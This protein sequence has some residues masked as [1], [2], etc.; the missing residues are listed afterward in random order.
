MVSYERIGWVNGTGSPLNASNLNKIDDGILELVKAVNENT[1]NITKNT[2]AIEA[3]DD[4]ADELQVS[5]NNVT[6]TVNTVKDTQAAHDTRI[7]TNTTNI[8][9]LTNAVGDSTKGLVKE[10]NDLKSNSATKTDITN[11]NT[12]LT[13]LSNTVTTLSGKVNTNE[14]DIS[15]IE[16]DVSNL[17]IRIS[18]AET[19]IDALK[20]NGGGSGGGSGAD[21]SQITNKP[22]T[23][24]PSKHVNSDPDKIGAATSTAYG[25]VKLDSGDMDTVTATTG[26]AAGRGHTHSNLA[27]KNPA[28]AD[29]D[30]LLSAEDKEKLDGIAAG[31]N[32]YVLPNIV[33]ESKVEST[34]TTVAFSIGD[35]KFSQ[36]VAVDGGSLSVGSAEKLTTARTIE[37]TGDVTGSAVFDGSVNATITTTISDD[38]H[39]H[40]ASTITSGTLALARIPTG[41]TSTTVALGNHTHSSY[42]NQN[43]FSN[44]TVGS[45]TIA[46]DS[47]TDTVTLVAGDNVTLTPDATNDKITIS[48]T[49]TT[50]SA[51]A[52][53]SLSGTTFSNSGVRSVK[54]NSSNG[55]K[56]EINTNGTTATI[57]IP[58]NDTTYSAG[59]GI[60]LSG[61]TFSNSGVLSI[62]QNV[63]DGHKLE[64]NTNGTTATITIP[65]NNTKVTSASN[66]YTPSTDTESTLSVDASDATTTASWNTTNIVTGVNITRDAKGHV[67][68]VTVDSV[69]MP[70]NPDTD[71]TYS[72]GTGLNL[73]GTTFSNAGVRSITQDTTDKHKLTINTNGT[74]ATITIPDN[75]TTYNIATSST[76]GLVKSGGDVTVGTDGIMSVAD[77]SHNHVISNID[78]L[79]DLLNLLNWQSF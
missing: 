26:I 29:A 34:G 64:I 15:G 7:I 77:D 66:H 9:L 32:K 23:F 33:N 18:A 63:L 6:T 74:T 60:S 14:N 52:G 30:G 79:Q 16:T 62:K 17:N 31:A 47:T 4:R 49:D 36:V 71:T 25:H 55:H 40:S 37:L 5:L 78:G 12:N 69:K 13:A 8:S 72:A 70:A 39:N 58:D 11:M 57:T 48:A 54:Q 38:S 35:K 68:G 21:W 65:D 75:D 20:E 3:V 51:G 76:A 42:V 59:T 2:N 53:L 43:A 73:S 45:T 24:P 50:Y 22:A 61:T 1:G 28:T 46:A 27:T 41:T 56:L 44:I 19:E 10:V 67:T